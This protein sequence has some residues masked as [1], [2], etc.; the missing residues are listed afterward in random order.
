VVPPWRVLAPRRLTALARLVGRTLWH[1][2]GANVD[3]ARRIWTP[4]L[5]ITPGVVIVPTRMTGDAG[6][7]TMGVLTSLV[8]D[9]QV[10]DLNPSAST[11]LFHCIE[12]PGDTV[13]ERRAAINGPTEQAI[14]RVGAT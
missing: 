1:V 2:S 4:S 6:L 14:A 7:T 9:N 10:I 13:D 12:V 11:A 8:V 5:P 3:L